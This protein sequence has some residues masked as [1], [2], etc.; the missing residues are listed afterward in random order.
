MIGYKNYL[1]VISLPPKQEAATGVVL[2]K[3]RS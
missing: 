1:R 3:N 2:Y